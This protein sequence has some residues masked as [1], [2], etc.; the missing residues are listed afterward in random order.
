MSTD[1]INR[2]ESWFASNQQRFSPR[3]LLLQI[4]SYAPADSLRGGINIAAETSTRLGS[5]CF[6]NKGEVT[7]MVVQR[8][9][10]QHETLDDRLQAP[11][12]GVEGLLERFFEALLGE[13]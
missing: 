12:E 3:C 10:G 5:I 9:S 8:V 2:V 13:Q 7:S 1:T 6:W 4:R 11:G